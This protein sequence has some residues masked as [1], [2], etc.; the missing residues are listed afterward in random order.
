VANNFAL[1]GL[2]RLQRRDALAV[3]QHG[4]AIREGEN[5]VELVRN[6]DASNALGFELSHDAQ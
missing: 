4:E 2:L 5:F 3:A 1:I 6:V